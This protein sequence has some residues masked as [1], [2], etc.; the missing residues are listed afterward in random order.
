MPKE[1]YSVLLDTSFL[2]R[3]LSREDSLYK[4]ADAF[5]RHFLE[6]GITMKVST[7]AVGEFCVH[8]SLSEFPLRNVQILPYN[9]PHAVIAGRF[10]H[11]LYELRERGDIVA[12][13]RAII[14]NDVKQ[15]AQAQFES[16]IRYFVTA[17]SSSFKKY[18]QHISKEEELTYEHLDIREVDYT[19][20]F[21][22]LDLQ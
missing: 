13:P 12:S 18:T 1:E 8:N 22:T 20:F 4:N 6:N 7:V 3:L 2:L 17:D 9:F 19:N 10:A 16:D 21:A 5:F 15:L 11:I 14:P